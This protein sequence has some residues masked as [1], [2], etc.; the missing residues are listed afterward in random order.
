MWS[1]VEMI[2]LDITC[3]VIILWCKE[4]R[5]VESIIF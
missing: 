5:S 2:L 1:M 4:K 3:K